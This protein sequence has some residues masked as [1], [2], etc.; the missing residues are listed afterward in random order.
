MAGTKARSARGLTVD[1][2]LL[3]IR[4]AIASRPKTVKVQE[5]E[6]YIESKSRR[7]RKKVVKPEDTPEALEEEAK[8]EGEENED[9]TEE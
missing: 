2:D 5:R 8:T 7:R 9:K 4:D 1:F 6:N 3:R